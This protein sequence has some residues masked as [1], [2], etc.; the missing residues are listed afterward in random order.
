MRFAHFAGTGE[1]FRVP[2]GLKPPELPKA[3][4]ANPS[5]ARSIRTSA[6]P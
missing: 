1:Y 4:N 5:N 3:A 2:D 6:M